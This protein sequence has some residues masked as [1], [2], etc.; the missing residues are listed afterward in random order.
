MPPCLAG[1][2]SQAMGMMVNAV[3][4]HVEENSSGNVVVKLFISVYVFFSTSFPVS[5]L[6]QLGF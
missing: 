6:L 2:A 1:F 4:W 3:S 5:Q